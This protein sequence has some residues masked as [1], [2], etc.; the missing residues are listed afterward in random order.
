M[1]NKS[2]VKTSNMLVQAPKDAIREGTE[3]AN[4]LMEVVRKGNLASNINGKEY[5]R[6]E[7]WQT[8]ARFYGYTVKTADTKFVK[9]NGASGFESRAVVI[10]VAN[11]RIVGGAE[12]ICM[13]DEK[14]W[15]N[16]PLY[17]LKSMA[18]TRAS[19]KALRQVLA[20]VAVLAGFEATPAEEMGNGED[21]DP[22]WI[23]AGDSNKCPHCGTTN[24][25]HAKDCPNRSTN[26]K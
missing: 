11:G 1:N 6:F 24:K 20:W 18:Q 9:Y 23:K 19:A 17:A 15:S 2:I 14:N 21:K 7:A 25:Y 4:S 10:Q 5:L 12:A 13:N 3:A 16:R 26:S 22:A 8:I